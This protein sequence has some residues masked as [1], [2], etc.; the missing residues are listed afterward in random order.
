MLLRKTARF[1]KTG[2]MIISFAL[3]LSVSGCG[4]K[5]QNIS[6]NQNTE[7][8]IQGGYE[9]ISEKDE[10]LDVSL[11]IYEEFSKKGKLEDLETVRSIVNA[12]GENEYPAVDSRNQIDMVNAEQVIAFH[13]M[14]ESQKDAE[15]TIIQV[16]YQNNFVRYD[17]LT[18]GGNVEVFRTYYA[19]ENQTVRKEV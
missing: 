13:E 12:F 3:I 19:Y 11:K 16:D 10:I 9:G 2:L 6:N 14:V 4:D 5:D 15:I 17:L 18:Q 1:W 8:E 7:T